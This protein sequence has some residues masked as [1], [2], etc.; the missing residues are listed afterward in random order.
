MPVVFAD[1]HREQRT[2]LDLGHGMAEPI[3]R[4]RARLAHLNPAQIRAE[5]G[6]L[7]RDAHEQGLGLLA[8][9]AQQMI[10]H[11]GPNDGRGIASVYL[12]AMTDA[13]ASSDFG[14]CDRHADHWLALVA[15]R[16]GA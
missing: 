8:C 9:L 13:A 7:H 5:A 16:L 11:M 15:V 12:E 10:R 14:A 2:V 3:R 4:L 1:N 6:H